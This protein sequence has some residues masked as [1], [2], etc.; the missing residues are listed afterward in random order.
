MNAQ[1]GSSASEAGSGVHSG[2][3]GI[4]FRAIGGCRRIATRSAERQAGGLAIGAALLYRGIGRGIPGSMKRLLWAL[5]AAFAVLVVTFSL[6]FALFPRDTLKTR[7]GEQIAAWT[8]RDVSLRG[9]PDIDFF[10]RL[11]VTLKDVRIGGPHDMSD[12]EILSMDR[13]EGTIRIMPLVIGRVEV[14]SFT[15][16]RPRIRLVRD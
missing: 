5:A 2:V 13:L 1:I 6:L 11:T 12:A 8:G 9:E 4:V 3:S 14:G 10:P 15:M 7:I 16:V